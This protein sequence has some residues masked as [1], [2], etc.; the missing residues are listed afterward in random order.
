MTVQIRKVSVWRSGLFTVSHILVCGVSVPDLR[1]GRESKLS[2]DNTRMPQ[3]HAQ[4]VNCV[5]YKLY[6][7]L[8]P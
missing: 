1:P 6:N 2:R 7:G 4:F 3:L 8:L 5:P